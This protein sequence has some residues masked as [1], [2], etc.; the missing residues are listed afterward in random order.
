MSD[1]TI[2][3]VKAEKKDPR[4]RMAHNVIKEVEALERND[5]WYSSAVTSDRSAS[6]DFS[7]E[8]LLTVA[9]GGH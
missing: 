8:R 9:C 5:S 3:E 4:Y 1:D 2:E 7:T 6:S